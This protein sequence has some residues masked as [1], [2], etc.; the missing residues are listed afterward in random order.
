MFCHDFQAKYP[1]EAIAIVQKWSDEHP[2]KTYRDD[3]FEKFPG[4]VKDK[5]GYPLFAP[6]YIYNKDLFRGMNH[7]DAWDKVMEE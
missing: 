2:P 1:D 5:D 3:F 6:D 7:Y 4:A